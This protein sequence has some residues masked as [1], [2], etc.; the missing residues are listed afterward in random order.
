M[1][2]S[3]TGAKQKKINP[4]DVKAALEAIAGGQSIRS[5]AKKFAVA[6][7]TLLR[8]VKRSE[9]VDNYQYDPNYAWHQVFNKKEE[10]EL[11]K[12]VVTC[13]RM[14]YGLSYKD[15]RKLAFK[16]ASAKKENVPESW[17]TEEIAGK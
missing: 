15:V 7:T 11:V 3:K 16:Y 13:A 14:H 6:S 12:Y 5:A 9:T 1:P 10:D 2:R 17:K 4:A 8:A